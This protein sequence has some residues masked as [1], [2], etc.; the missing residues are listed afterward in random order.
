LLEGDP[1]NY[2]AYATPTSVVVRSS[3]QTDR[4]RL[5]FLGRALDKLGRFEDSEKAYKTAGQTRPDDDQ[6]TKG[7]HMLYEV[8]GG[9]KV[10]EYI[11][12]TVRI[13]QIHEAACV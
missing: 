11:D 10:D 2:F 4:T 7:L 6:A 8:Q 12:T 3:S 13:A 9:A 5:L 1:E